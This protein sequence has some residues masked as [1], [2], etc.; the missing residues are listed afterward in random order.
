M[1]GWAS[2]QFEK[3][4]Q[5]VAPPPADANGRFTYA[6]Q[7]GD[8]DGAMAC[9]PEMDAARAVLNPTKRSYAIHI[10]CLH[11]MDRLIRLL[12][13]QPGVDLTFI[14]THGNT[15]LHYATMSTDKARALSTIKMLVTEFKASVIAKNSS[16]QTPYD[17]ASLDGVRQYLLPL[18]LQEET[19]IAID[20]G[21]V[22]LPP[23]IDMGGLRISNPVAP[24]PPMGFG[25]VA[26]APMSSPPPQSYPKPA[27]DTPQPPTSGQAGGYALS[28][29]SSAAIYKPSSAR[30]VKADGFHSSS[31]DVSLQ[32]KYGHVQTQYG[33]VAPPPTSG[34]AGA[35]AFP[36]PGQPPQAECSRQPRC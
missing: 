29:G 9:V 23:G 2:Q 11:S 24:P 36:P 12:L 26:P 33:N 34:N 16:G 30:Y 25:G 3:L 10:A 7:R 18:Q 32:R 4:S 35:S 20:N 13:T 5:T 17:L 31:S 22:G 28:G 8:E 1:L 21:G 14:D 6:V 19:R 15:P 27:H